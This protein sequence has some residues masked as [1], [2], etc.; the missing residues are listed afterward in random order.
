MNKD[1]ILK[2]SREQKEDEGVIH[3]ENI[4]RRYG[5]YGLSAMFSIYALIFIFIGGNLTVPMSLWFA[6]SGAELLGKY[7]TYKRKQDLFGSIVL[8]LVSIGFL[9]SYLLID[10]LKVIVY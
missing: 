8:I 7:R 3:Q 1:E 9:L 5:F 4:G 10:L 2:R 6:F